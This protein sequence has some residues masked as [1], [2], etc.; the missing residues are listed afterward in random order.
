MAVLPA[1]VVLLPSAA[2]AET[3]DVTVKTGDAGHAGTNANVAIR[4]FSMMPASQTVVDSG[5]LPLV[6]THGHNDFPRNSVRKFRV[7]T[8]A[9]VRLK[10]VYGLEVDQDNSGSEP[11]WFLKS[12]EVRSVDTGMTKTF[13]CDAWLNE[14]IGTKRYLKPYENF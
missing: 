14:K 10:N 2:L 5:K 3:F 8:P 6:S 7:T 1:A 13:L 12:I 11:D 4:L 9:N